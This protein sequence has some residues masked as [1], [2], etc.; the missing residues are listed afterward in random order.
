M[1]SFGEV[2]MVQTRM[3]AAAYTEGGKDWEK[4]FRE[5]DKNKSGQI[6]WKEFLSMC[7]R[8]LKI[9]QKTFS[10]FGEASGFDDAELGKVFK[11]LD[12]DQ[13]GEISIDELCAFVAEGDPPAPESSG[14][15]ATG[16]ARF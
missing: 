6:D 9:P 7:R 1:E 13:S 10:G 16:A 11:A 5:Q 12:G 3:K 15:G 4:L 14:E 2:E 8:V